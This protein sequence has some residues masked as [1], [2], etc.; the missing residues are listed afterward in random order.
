MLL[1]TIPNG[2]SNN[3]IDYLFQDFDMDGNI[4]PYSIMSASQVLMG[5]DKGIILLDLSCTINGEEFTDINLFITAL[6]AE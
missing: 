6:R 5:T 3:G 2:Y 4:V 1:V